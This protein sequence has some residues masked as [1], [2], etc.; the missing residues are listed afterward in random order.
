[1]SKTSDDGKRKCTSPSCQVPRAWYIKA[2]GPLAA[3]IYRFHV[4]MMSHTPG[5]G[6]HEPETAASIGCLP[7]INTI[8]IE[9][10][11]TFIHCQRLP[12][13][14]E[15]APSTEKEVTGTSGDSLGRTRLARHGGSDNTQAR[16]G[17]LPRASVG[18]EMQSAPSRHWQTQ[19]SSDE[20]RLT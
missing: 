20:A 9:L 13:E 14:A 10:P 11:T 18:C 19:V 1:M 17:S 4:L 3:S 15:F 7:V 12:A 2:S 16:P 8:Q 5:R 6:R